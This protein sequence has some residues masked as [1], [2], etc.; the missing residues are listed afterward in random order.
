MESRSTG[1]NQVPWKFHGVISL[2]LAYWILLRVPTLY[3]ALSALVCVPP[4]LYPPH[5]P[6]FRNF[7]NY[8]IVIKLARL[9]QS[10]PQNSD[11]MAF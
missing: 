9:S 1:P 6:T 4:F 5:P 2:I 3:P 7:R 8:T 11:N 10:Q